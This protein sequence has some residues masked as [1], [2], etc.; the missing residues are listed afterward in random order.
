MIIALMSKEEILAVIDPIKFVGRAPSQ[1]VEFIDEY[2]NP[3][4]EDNKEALEIKS[5]ITV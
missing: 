4:I 2:V 3:I 1:V 5:E